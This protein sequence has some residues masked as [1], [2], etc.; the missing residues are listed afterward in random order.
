MTEVDASR[1]ELKALWA[2]STGHAPAV[3]V[4]V[5][6][7]QLPVFNSAHVA[8]QFHENA[9]VTGL[10]DEEVSYVLE[11]TP[12]QPY[13][14]YRIR[15]PAKADYPKIRRFIAAL[16]ADMPHV[17]LDGIRC[18]RENTAAAVLACDLTFSAFF[19]LDRNG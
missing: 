4:Q 12:G 11:A 19:Q 13:Q 14:R 15:F 7:P 16:G 2:A 10:A 1:V 6:V 3:P 8:A 5:G 9:I 18:A 17:A